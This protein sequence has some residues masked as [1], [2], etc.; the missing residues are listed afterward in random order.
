MIKRNRRPSTP[1]IILKKLY[2]E[3]RN[4]KVIDL[5]EATGISRKHLSQIVTGPKRLSPDVAHKLAVVL[6]TTSQVWL[7]HQAAIDAWDADHA[8]NGWKPSR[9]FYAVAVTT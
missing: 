2:M 5:E 1:G 6:N 8:D 4:I 3:P 7:N 9:T